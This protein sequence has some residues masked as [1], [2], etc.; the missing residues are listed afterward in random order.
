MFGMFFSGHGV[1]VLMCQ[2]SCC[3]SS[4]N[5]MCNDFGEDGAK[6]LSEALEVSSSRQ[7]QLQTSCSRGVMAG[8]AGK[9]W[10]GVIAHPK[11]WAVREL[12]ENL[13]LVK[14]FFFNNKK[15]FGLKHHHFGASQKKMIFLTLLMSSVC[16]L[17]CLLEDCDLLPYLL[18]QPIIPLCGSSGAGSMRKERNILLRHLRLIKFLLVLVVFAI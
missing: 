13:H 1:Y 3:M 8:A 2:T 10:G 5:L 15:F 12:L 18:F 9:H 4:L 6:H 17:Q 7:Q 11:V 16:N 14:I